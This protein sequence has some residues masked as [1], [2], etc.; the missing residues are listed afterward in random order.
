MWAGS[1]RRGRRTESGGRG[2]EG[3]EGR[4]RDGEGRG[5]DEQR[6]WKRERTKYKK[7]QGDG[8]TG[9]GRETGRVRNVARAESGGEM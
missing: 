2:T 4:D 7:L 8:E 9:V 6:H 5:R 1:G 3:E